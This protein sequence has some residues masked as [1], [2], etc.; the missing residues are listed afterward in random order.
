MNR[1]FQIVPYDPS[2]PRRHARAAARLCR[3]LGE[4][5][6]AVQVV[7]TA[8]PGMPAQPIIDLLLEVRDLAALRAYAKRGG[9]ICNA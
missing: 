6:I 7:G 9:A 2:W 1:R 8:V 4:E 5:V 3:V